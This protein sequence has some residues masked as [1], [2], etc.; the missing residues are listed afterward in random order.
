MTE[1]EAYI[2]QLAPTLGIDPDVAV[3]VARSEGGLVDPFR[4]GEG[5]PPKSQAPGLGST[6][7]SYGPFQLYISGNNAGL[8]D[9]AVA[10]GVDPQK[11]WKQG[12]NYALTE[13]A[14]KGWGQW[15]GA[16]NSGIDT[17]QGIT[18]GD[19][20]RQFALEPQG[21][22]SRAPTGRSRRLAVVRGPIASQHALRAP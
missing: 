20:P 14:N 2:R 6:E 11:D 19:Q 17:W 9:R 4:R 3:A 5:P 8:G 18:R 16:A 21:G 22:F 7:N 13:A 15:Y 12:V 10:S 1:I